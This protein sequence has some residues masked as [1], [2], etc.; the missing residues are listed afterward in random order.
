MSDL[1]LLLLAAVSGLAGL[2]LVGFGTRVLVHELNTWVWRRSLVAFEVRIP[3]AV[4]TDDVARWLG[5]VRS[6]VPQ[7]RWWSIL[8]R[9]PFCLETTATRHGIRHVVVIPASRRTAVLATL[10]AAIPGARLVKLTNYMTSGD[11]PRFQAATEIRLRGGGELLATDRAADTSRHLIAALQPLQPGETIRVQWLITGARAPRWISH[12]DVD[13][14]IPDLWQSGPVLGA[15]GRVAVASP[16]SRYRAKA[17][18]G[19]VWSAMGGMNTPRT[20]V[21]RRWWWPRFAVAARLVLRVVPRGRWPIIATTGELA[22]LLGLAMGTDVLP[23]VPTE[24]S[25]TLPPSPSMPTTGLV[26]AVSNYPGVRAPLCVSTSDRLRHMWILGPTGTGKSTLLCNII[27]HDIAHGDGLVLIDAGGDL[28]ADVLDR[29]PDSRTDDIVVIDP[30]HTDHIIGLNPLTAGLPEQ[31]AGFTYHV[32]QS[33]WSA[34]W[35]PRS[36]DITRACLLTLTAATVSNNSAFT[37]IDIPE[38]LTNAGFRRYITTQSLPPQLM[39]FWRWYDHMPQPQQ[40]SMISPV[41]N[42][43]RTFTLSS[44]LRAT[45]GQ[46]NGV[47]FADVLVNGR[48]VL[49]ALKKAILGDEVTALLGALVMASVWQAVQTRVNIP[50]HQ[51]SPFWLVAD[52]FQETLRLPLNLPDMAA[53]ARGLGLGLVL[54]HQY[55]DQLTP[56]VKAAVLDT[57]RSQI[58]FQVERADATELAPAFAPLTATDLHHLGAFEVA[59]RLCTNGAT[60]PPVTGTTYPA[61]EPTRDGAALA[62]ASRRRHG[63][64]LA[65]VDEQITKRVT[66]PTTR[67]TTRWN[68][69][70]GGEQP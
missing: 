28:V 29:I 50:K 69:I 19:R 59:A 31:A 18:L 43:L 51:R 49:V 62:A 21:A 26:V 6:L 25:R 57:I 63:L 60:A 36:A 42:K 39:K 41:L 55:L 9:S 40:L 1:L 2:V 3:R 34:N 30:T 14:D 47:Q 15:V 5:L 32:L 8:P 4:D 53:R 22:G 23:G 66:P 16:L 35:G 65:T 52:E 64:P 13:A 56:A 37:L 58:V 24:I 38:L 48:V 10:S 70:P 7:R 17:V 44:A 12:F 54:A 46:S 61:P 45:L 67:G 27:S 20:K 33:L 68:R 11:G